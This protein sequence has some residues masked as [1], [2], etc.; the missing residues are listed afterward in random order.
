MMHLPLQERIENGFR[1][2]LSGLRRVAPLAKE[3]QNRIEDAAK[4]G[5]YRLAGLFGRK[6]VPV[7]QYCP[8]KSERRCR[9]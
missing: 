1:S 9:R 6:P 7:Y 5:L 2:V 8:A 3:A 4:G